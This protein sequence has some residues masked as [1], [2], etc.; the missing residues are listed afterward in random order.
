MSQQDTQWL[1]VLRAACRAPN[2]SQRLVSE[3]L[4][5]S[6]SVISQALAGKYRG[7]L[8]ALRTKV[9]GVLMGLSVE[10]P[11]VGDL[12]R[13]RCLDYQRQ[14]F[15][16]TNHLRVQLSRSCPTCPHNRSRQQ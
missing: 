1:D 2:S 5:Y 13:N 10:C 8:K 6:C 4:G 9:E 11:V 3:R 7:D 16:A 15:A 12:P 14:A